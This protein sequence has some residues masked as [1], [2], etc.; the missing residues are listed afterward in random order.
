MKTR[1]ILRQKD[2]VF[3]YHATRV[4]VLY[5]SQ[6]GGAPPVNTDNKWFDFGSKY[7]DGS[8]NKVID[9]LLTIRE[10]IPDE[11]RATARCEISN[12]SEFDM[13]YA[14]IHVSYDRPE[15][16]EETAARKAK[17]KQEA[18][19]RERIERSMFERLKARFEGS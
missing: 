13:T 6:Y 9:S 17:D 14:T 18:N 11:Y 19:E 16:P 4:V 10:S 8:L 5:Q 12:D 15:T 1:S 7:E 2:S 3:H